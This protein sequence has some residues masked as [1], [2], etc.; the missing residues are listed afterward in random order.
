MDSS[1]LVGLSSADVFG[2]T[3][4]REVGKEMRREGG[5]KEGTVKS[6]MY[7]FWEVIKSANKFLWMTSL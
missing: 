7:T 3:Q 4:T 2:L 1:R 6:V 5:G